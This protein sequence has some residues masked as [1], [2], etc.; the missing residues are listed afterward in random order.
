M[1]VLT[2]E[3]FMR[4]N[5]SQKVFGFKINEHSPEIPIPEDRIKLLF[6]SIHNDDREM[7]ISARNC[8]TLM[9]NNSESNNSE[10]LKQEIEKII[11]LGASKA[12]LDRILTIYSKACE[13]EKNLEKL[14]PPMIFLP[15]KFINEIK[16]K[17]EIAKLLSILIE[18]A[19]ADKKENWV[20][21]SDKSSVDGQIQIDVSK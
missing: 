18:A 10:L 20:S 4:Y 19:K 6:D 21:I 16:R 12:P 2:H 9:P 15:K 11:V 17:A 7:L 13:I 14:S 1:T 5:K 3:M 8:I